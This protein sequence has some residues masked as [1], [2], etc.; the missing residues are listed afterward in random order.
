MRECQS[1]NERL[2]H[3]HRGQAPSHMFERIYS[4]ANLSVTK[5]EYI[6]LRRYDERDNGEIARGSCCQRAGTEVA[7][8]QIGGLDST[9]NY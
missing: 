6:D 4:L 9:R 7:D 1:P 2:I 8:G 3:R 5:A